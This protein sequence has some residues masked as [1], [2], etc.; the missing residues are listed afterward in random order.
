MTRIVTVIVINYRKPGTLGA[1]EKTRCPPPW[2]APEYSY[3]RERYIR[4]R[5]ASKKNLSIFAQG[6]YAVPL[7]V[8]L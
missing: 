1:K 4:Q 8:G 3:R 7:V 2:K 5:D 6:I